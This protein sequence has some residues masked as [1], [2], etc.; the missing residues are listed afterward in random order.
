MSGSRG[1]VVCFYLHSVFF[2]P[3]DFFPISGS[4]LQLRA[5]CAFGS[6]AVDVTER[7]IRSPLCEFGS[8]AASYT[9]L[10]SMVSHAVLSQEE[11]VLRRVR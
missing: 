7:S 4:R 6:G 11:F 10:L 2:T 5:G 3:A 9:W 8:Y 1:N